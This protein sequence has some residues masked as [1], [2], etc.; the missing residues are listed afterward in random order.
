MCFKHGG[1]Y[2]LRG[3]YRDNAVAGVKFMKKNIGLVV[4]GIVIGIIL[5]AAVYFF[6]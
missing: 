5:V 3:K 4:L 6:I 2:R 1:E